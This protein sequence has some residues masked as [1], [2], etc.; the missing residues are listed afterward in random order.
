MTF[1]EPELHMWVLADL[2]SV[3]NSQGF[4]RWWW[5]GGVGVSAFSE[6]F[7][8]ASS[9]ENHFQ[10]SF[11]KLLVSLAYL[12]IFEEFPLYLDGIRGISAA[13]G[14]RFTPRPDTV[15]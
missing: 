12:K 11:F 4:H 7:L 14:L 10:G 13:A 15:D 2:F 9:S 6:L 3:W 5:A 1:Q 8:P